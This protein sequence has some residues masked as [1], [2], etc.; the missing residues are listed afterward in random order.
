MYL[1]SLRYFLLMDGRYLDLPDLGFIPSPYAEYKV[2]I[3]AISMVLQS[4]FALLH[5]FAQRRIVR[6]YASQ[7]LWYQPF[8][9]WRRTSLGPQSVSPP[10]WSCCVLHEWPVISPRGS[11]DNFAFAAF[12][13]LRAHAARKLN[14]HSGLEAAICCICKTLLFR[15]SGEQDECPKA[16]HQSEAILDQ[17]LCFLSYEKRRRFFE[18]WSVQFARYSLREC[19]S[20]STKQLTAQTF[21]TRT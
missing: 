3:V 12:S 17:A 1:L 9:H 5:I 18:E 19:Q 16:F 14:S 20:G 11:A 6:A 2:I 13:V 4:I 21:A 7:I 8:E 10:D 15:Y